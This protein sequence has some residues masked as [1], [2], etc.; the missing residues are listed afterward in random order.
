MGCIMKESKLFNAIVSERTKIVKKLNGYNPFT[1]DEEFFKL[2]DT[3]D[4][5]DTYISK[6]IS[7]YN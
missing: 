5:M 4:K 7:K 3:K 1:I 6:H 2:H